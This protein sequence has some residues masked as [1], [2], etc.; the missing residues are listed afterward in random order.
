MWHETASRLALTAALLAAT[1]TAAAAEDQ[2][3]GEDQTKVTQLEEIVVTAQKRAESLQDV[4]MAVTAMSG[5]FLSENDIHAFDEIAG[6]T[7]GL[8]FSAFTLGQPEIA[9]RG[10]ST[11]EDGPAASDAVVVSI[12]DIYIAARSAQVFDIFDLERVEIARGPQGTLAG[13]NSVAGSVNFVTLQPGPETVVRFRQSVGN[14]D[15]FDTQG[16]LSGRIAN[17]LYG[18]VSFS[19]RKHD[20]F[21]TN[22]LPGYTDPV[23]GLFVQNPDFGKDQGELDSFYWRAYLRYAP[24]DAPFTI[25]LIADVGDEDRGQSNREPVGSLGPL[26][27]CGCASDPVAVNIALGGA[28]DPWTTLAETDGFAKRDMWGV[29]LKFDYAL[30]FADFLLIAN[31]RESDF[32]FLEDSEGLPPFAPTI[33]LTGSSGSPVPL[34]TA[35][36]DRG[37]TFDISD[38]ADEKSVQN[39]LEARLTSPG[40]GRWAWVVGALLSFEDINRIERFTFPT[41]GGPAPA[42]FTTVAPPFG[43]SDSQ[44]DQRMNGTSFGIFGQAS[45]DLTDALRLTAGLRWSY[46]RKEV[47]VENTLFSGL[48]LLLQGFPAVRAKASWDDVSWRVALDYRVSPNAMVYALVSTGFKS[49][50]FVGEPTTADVATTPFGKE[51]A[52]NYEAGIKADAFDRRLRVN[53]A[54]FWTQIEGLQ[55]TRFFQPVGSGFGQF[56]TENAGKARSRGVEVELTALLADGLEVGANYGYLNAEYVNFTGLPSVQPDGSILEPG[57]FNGNQMRE[58]PPHS[59]SGYVQYTH[60]LDWGEITARIDGR[61]RD[62]MFFDPSN[63]PISRADAHDVWDA[64]LAWRSPDQHWELAL[65]GKNIFEEKYITHLFTQRGGR[66]AFALF[67]EPRRYGLSLTY[68]Y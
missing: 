56:I 49:G 21:L 26:H 62:R 51:T 43:T 53:I 48:P 30:S 34:L 5:D 66:I 8:V 1:A 65:W 58:A 4:P 25:S 35:P 2:A 64:R 41:L 46:D 31:H 12:D 54:A 32:S 50:G 36:A 23:S 6:R 42:P 67:G 63:N 39:T 68:S 52:R 44:S 55:V 9:L 16:L 45:Y 33:D 14:Y 19:R 20:G 61:F 40:G 24:D 22:V 17:G 3:A 10:I 57:T 38:A 18:K 37:F 59:A 27:D 29:A 7:P 60:R 15:T 11:K 47:R 13:K 28:G